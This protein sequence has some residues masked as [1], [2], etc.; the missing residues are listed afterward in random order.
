M[1]KRRKKR[2]KSK[3]LNLKN[4]KIK[5][6]LS[7]AFT[8]IL[9]IASIAAI[10]GCIAMLVLSNRYSYTLT[11]FAFPQGTIGKAMTAFSEARSSLRAAIG[12][13]EEEDIQT[14][15]KVHDEQKALF[16]S[17]MKEIK[18]TIVS[19]EGN[20]AYNQILAHLEDYWEMDAKIL[21]IGTTTDREKCKEAQDLAL[22]QL[23]PL[24]SQTYSDLTNLLDINISKGDNMEKTLRGLETFLIIFIVS[25][26][27]ISFFISMK[28][29]NYIASGIEKPLHA[30]ALRLKTFAQGN[31]E[32]PFPDSK[33]N[34]EIS[35][36]TKEAKG[37]ADNLGM[38]IKDSGEVLSKMAEG[39][40][41]ASTKIKERYVGAFA[42]LNAAMEKVNQQMNETLHQIDDAS[43]LVSSGSG[44]LASAAQSMAEGATD[45]AGAVEELQATFTNIAEGVHKT[46]QSVE[47][48]YHHAQKYADEA[49]QSRTEMQAMVDAMSRINETSQKIGNI[50]SEI[51]DIASQTNLLS[52]NAAI[53]AARAGDAGRG[54]AV[55]AEQVRNLAEQSAK[56]AI[57]TRQLIE[58]SLHEV[59]EGNK[60]AERVASSLE[61]V[62][63]GIKQIAE[64]SKGLSDI[65]SSQAE[66]MEQ[67]ELGI[68]Q[69]SEVVQSNSATAQECSATS[70]ELSAQATSMSKLVSEFVL[71][72]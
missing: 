51:E 61:E 6:R 9:G 57:D 26:I 27:V 18:D 55:V 41:T 5:K 24:Y 33:T 67:A 42:S 21:S 68:N 59:E 14:V 4:M 17:Y 1:P 60:A 43:N 10:A 7:T 31:L 70:Q 15:V 11:Y 48:T 63:S 16:E 64:A 45:Q 46:A 37:M 39:N 58:G 30:L 3:M 56:S 29:G 34:D 72:K 47:D 49:D 44:N 25:I 32:D 53:E 19:D 12:Y 65:S 40:Y 35:E 66:A 28:L 13:D 62:I 50:I 8:L 69:I 54:F 52:L 36:M 38:I 71:K 2:R 20:N 23:T 22:N